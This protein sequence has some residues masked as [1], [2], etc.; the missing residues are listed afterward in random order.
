MC[1]LCELTKVCNGGK[2]HSDIKIKPSKPD[3]CT[4]I[5]TEDTDYGAKRALNHM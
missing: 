3:I 2:E 1:P 5:G 4:L